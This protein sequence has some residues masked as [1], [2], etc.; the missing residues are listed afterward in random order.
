MLQPRELYRAQGFPDSYIIGD[1]PS[2][3]LLLTKTQ[4]VSLCGN[5]VPPDVEAAIVAANYTE[6]SAQREGRELPLLGVGR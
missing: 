3:G 1:D 6:D 5:S 4:Q 2:Q